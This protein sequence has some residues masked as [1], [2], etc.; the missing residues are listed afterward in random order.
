MNEFQQEIYKT[1]D[2]IVQNRFKQ[3]GFDK[4]RRGKVITP[5]EDTCVV[6]INGTQYTCKIKKGL[7]V[8]KDDVV[9]VEFPQNNDSDKYIKE[10][11]S[12]AGGYGFLDML[13]YKYGSSIILDCGLP[14]SISNGTIIDGGDVSGL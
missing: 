10:V 14:N 11:I 12:G 3:L 2:I 13:G 7:N 4:T 8:A 6:E 1:I 9:R 5:G